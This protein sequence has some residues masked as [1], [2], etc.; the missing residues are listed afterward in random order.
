MAGSHREVQRSIPLV[1]VKPV[2]VAGFLVS[3]CSSNSCLPLPFCR[4]M[5]GAKKG[6]CGFK[7]WRLRAS[8]AIALDLAHGTLFQSGDAEILP[9]V[10]VG[11]T[12]NRRV[13]LRPRCRFWHALERDYLICIS[14]KVFLHVAASL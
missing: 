13:E 1:A 8:R 3:C 2:V 5:L 12:M 6:L 10:T 7:R 9:G 14:P 11:C 4:G